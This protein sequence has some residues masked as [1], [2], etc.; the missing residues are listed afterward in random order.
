VSRPGF[1]QPAGRSTPSAA[2][3]WP[4]GKLGLAEI[5]PEILADAPRRLR[6]FCTFFM[7]TSGFFV[8]T[9]YLFPWWQFGSGLQLAVMWGVA[10]A[11]LVYLVQLQPEPGEVLTLAVVLEVFVAANVAFIVNS[12]PW[13]LDPTLPSWSPVAVFV[14]IYAFVVP[15]TIGR[16]AAGAIISAAMDPAVTAVLALR[17]TIELP[18]M[19]LVIYRFL[20]N[21]GAVVFATLGSRFIF[22]LGVQLQRA[23]Q[24]GAYHLA[25]KIGS[26]G[27]G[28]VW[29]AS[30][31]MLS[32]PAAIKLIR[33][34]DADPEQARALLTRFEREAQ[35][36]AQLCSPHTVDVYDF[37]ISQDGSFYY[38]M[39]LLDGIDMRTL[40]ER[41]G[42]QPPERVAAFM[43]QVCHSLRE[44][45]A[46]GLLHRDI[47]PANL[48]VC[49]Y[50][51]DFDFVKVLDFGLAKD[52]DAG[53]EAQVT[54][55]GILA[56]TP[57]FL[58][59]ELATGEGEI[60]GRADL[61]ALGCVGYWLLTGRL[62]F[63]APS[64]AA[65]LV[66]HARDEPEPLATAAEI[67][68]PPA[69]EA[70]IHRCLSKRPEDRP[71]TAAEVSEAVAEIAR[72]WTP[73]NAEQ[74][75][76]AHGRGLGPKAA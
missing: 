72:A 9:S 33:A 7:G 68:T 34:D 62:V 6:V 61:Y 56:G 67:E 35:A 32:R 51:E 4:T 36:T 48:M 54:R 76:R 47:K 59:P 22:R 52:L 1:V 3:R 73:A 21:L 26:G 43:T 19:S 23:R 31:Q 10:I 2:R 57:A 30:H 45:H 65:M 17:G 49:R 25:E 58:P 71:A 5:P 44:A 13:P 50:G 63:E 27:M 38:V 46:R 39:E 64:A 40:V 69:L 60:D 53:E 20:P 74:W 75:W 37:G 41:F 42:P 18:E 11:V 12:V 70:V 29:R 16:A 14:L 55:Q 24:L 15:N 28:D 66:A 8:G